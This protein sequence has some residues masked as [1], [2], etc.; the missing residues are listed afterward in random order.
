VQKWFNAC[1]RGLLNGS[2]TIRDIFILKAKYNYNDRNNDIQITV[3]HKNV[4]SADDLPA[5]IDMKNSEN[6]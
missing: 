6:P 1:E 4:I 3:N 5:L 2:D